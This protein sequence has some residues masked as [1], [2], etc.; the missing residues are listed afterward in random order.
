VRV[1]GGDSK[2][3][4]PP[5]DSSNVNSRLLLVLLLLLSIFFWDIIGESE[6]L[7]NSDSTI[8]C[9]KKRQW[10]T[11]VASRPTVDLRLFYEKFSST[12]SSRARTVLTWIFTDVLIRRHERD[13]T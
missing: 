11:L 1:W 12:S 9:P 13:W 6:F 4:I 5:R 3:K 10:Q 2:K 7:G 8:F